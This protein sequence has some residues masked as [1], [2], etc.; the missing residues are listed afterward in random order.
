MEKMTYARAFDTDFSIMLRNKKSASL[1]EMQEKSFDIEANLIAAG[2]IKNVKEEG[3]EKKKGKDDVGPSQNRKDPME[4]KMEK[5]ART[6][7]NLTNQ[8]SRMEVN[9]SPNQPRPAQDGERRNQNKNFPRR[10]FQPQMLRREE[11]RHEEGQMQAPM[12]NNNQIDDEIVEKI[13]E[14]DDGCNYFHEESE[15]MQMFHYDDH[16]PDDFG[17]SFGSNMPL[18]Y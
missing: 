13:N 3:K 11:R 10:G 4:E 15:Y 9:Q 17:F 5:M 1:Q 14:N 6:I 7:R 16:V 8:I 18:E 2:R 12:R